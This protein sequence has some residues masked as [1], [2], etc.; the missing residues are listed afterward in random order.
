MSS[1]ES[2]KNCLV[3]KRL[4][5]EREK[6]DISQDALGLSV[7]ASKR[8]VVNWERGDSAPDAWQLAAMIDKHGMDILY[9]ITGQRTP[10][11][12][13]RGRSPYT[14]AERA[15]EKIREMKLC[16][17][18]ANILAMFAVRLEKP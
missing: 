15:A 12:V 18:D 11:G 5:E 3:G 17:E 16:E 9:I 8:T 14:P 1:G 7:D 4:K 10:L 13:A 6:K 2:E